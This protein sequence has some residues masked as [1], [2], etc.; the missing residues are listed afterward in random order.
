MGNDSILPQ[1]KH[2]ITISVSAR[3][4]LT[5]HP[6]THLQSKQVKQLVQRHCIIM[7]ATLTG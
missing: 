7:F 3:H 4:G 2:N 5:T 6:A 1:A